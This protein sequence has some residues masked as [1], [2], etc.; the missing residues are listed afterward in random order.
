[1]IKLLGTLALGIIAFNNTSFALEEGEY[2]IKSCKNFYP[3]SGPIYAGNYAPHLDGPTRSIRVVSYNVNFATEVKKLM[4]DLSELEELK[5]ADVI[6]L[7]EVEGAPGGSGNFA[8]SAAKQLGLNY[9]FAPAEVFTKHNADYGNAILSRW[10]ILRFR[11]IMLPLSNFEN[12]NQRI[13]L[14]ATLRI[15]DEDVEVFSVHLSTLFKD[16]A[17][18]ENSRIEQMRPV[19]V[20]AGRVP[21]H[22]PVIVAGDLNTVNPYGWHGIEAMFEDLGFA[23]GHMK[24]AATFKIPPFHLDHMFVR[25]L[26][27]T[28]MGVS[29]HARGSDHYPIWSEVV[30]RHGDAECSA[31]Q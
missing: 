1:M 25:G 30:A 19:A 18:S 7:Q 12:C 3:P 2:D 17:G 31:E 16:S 8:K 22:V 15:G 14:E 23:N 6:L 24:R 11:K 9:V 26:C 21:A 28:K 27:P 4:S 5:N 13:A 29:H 10:P 20:A